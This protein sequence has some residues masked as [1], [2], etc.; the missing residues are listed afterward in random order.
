MPIVEGWAGGTVDVAVI[1]AGAAGIA[2]ARRLLARKGL[3]VLM[4]EAGPRIGGRAFTVHPRDLDVP[5]DLGCEWLHAAK[6]NAWT[7]IVERLGFTVDRQPAPWNQGD[8]RKFGL[9]PADRND[10]ERTAERFHQKLAAAASSGTDCAMGD[11][12][13]PASRWRALL[14]S[15]STYVSGAELDYVSCLDYERYQPG[16]GPDWRIVEGYGR[17]I[18]AYGAPIPVALATA[19]TRIDHSAADVV[20]IETSRGTLVSRAAIVTVS[21]DVLAAETIRFTPS[22]PDKL[23]AAANL[24][25]GLA[26]KVFLRIEG[27]ADLPAEGYCLGSP[28]RSTTAAYHIRPFG[29]PVIEAFYGGQLARDLEREGEAAAAAFATEELTDLFGAEFARHLVPLRA[30]AWAAEP[31]IRGSYS[32]A[33]PGAADCRAVLAEPVDDRLLFAGE[34]CSPKAFTTAHGAYASGVTAA[35]TVLARLKRKRAVT[36]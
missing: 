19:A 11:L 13:D 20:R 31:H 18:A 23:Q 8:R 1:G 6:T 2:A 24:P 29:R 26:D 7:G 32:Y 21:T 36:S 5:L 34:A 22:L 4:L 35:E 15:V 16:E 12:I 9:S 14:D 10:Y 25:L 28:V 3:S 33:K 30:S 17:A 27:S